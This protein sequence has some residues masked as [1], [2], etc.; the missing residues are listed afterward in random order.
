MALLGE[1]AIF[2]QD[3][4]DNKVFYTYLI[5]ENNNY[6]TKKGK[7][8]Q[9]YCVLKYEKR[10][11]FFENVNKYI[12]GK[13]FL[14][15]LLEKNINLNDIVNW[16]F[17]V[18]GQYLEGQ[19]LIKDNCPKEFMEIINIKNEIKFIYQLF[20]D[21][22]KFIGQ[23]ESIP[24]YNININNINDLKYITNPISIFLFNKQEFDFL[25]NSLFFN[26]IENIIK[27]NQIYDD[28]INEFLFN[29]LRK[30]PSQV[31]IKNIFSKINL[32]DEDQIESILKYQKDKYLFSFINIDLIQQIIN[33]NASPRLINKINDSH[34]LLFKNKNEY[35]I[36]NNGY[37]KIYKIVMINK[38]EFKLEK[39]KE[40][41]NK[42]IKDLINS[43]ENN[44][45]KERIKSLE[46]ENK[47]LN[48]NISRF[49]FIL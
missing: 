15:Y 19:C 46:K 49:P 25:K 23:I 34:F 26:D 41:K 27:G 11:L 37:P 39:F 36:T 9:L 40:N 30:L 33:I 16:Q 1:N 45:I 31:D 24:D 13:G 5:N 6:Y 10:N 48:E 21:Y 4:S 43:D 8:L 3:K 2:I 47:K 38:N 42:N 14:N 22:K 32:L 12:K 29:K 44:R 28:K 18:N 35:Y 17:L 20:I 7:N